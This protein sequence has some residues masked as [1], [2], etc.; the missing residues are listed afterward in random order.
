[1]I[2]TPFIL[3]DKTIQHLNYRVL[4]KMIGTTHYPYAQ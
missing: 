3:S 2:L 1:M 4:K